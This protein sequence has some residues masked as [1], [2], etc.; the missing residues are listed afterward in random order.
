MSSRCRRFSLS[1]RLAVN[2]FWFAK[3]SNK[4]IS[5]DFIFFLV[6]V[7][8]PVRFSTATGYPYIKKFGVSSIDRAVNYYFSHFRQ[9]IGSGAALV[10]RFRSF[11]AYFQIIRANSY[12]SA[13]FRLY[14]LISRLFRR[15]FASWGG[16]HV[17]V[18]FLILGR[19]GPGCMLSFFALGG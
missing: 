18:S 15:S 14:R 2:G 7:C 19:T 12:Y 5:A 3:R 10:A 11:S 9:K 8:I 17:A 4:K 1:Y 6:F 16:C 13:L